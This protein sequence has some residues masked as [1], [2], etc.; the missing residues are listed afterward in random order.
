MS[1]LKREAN[2]IPLIRRLNDHYRLFLCEYPDLCAVC[3]LDPGLVRGNNFDLTPNLWR[4]E[5]LQPVL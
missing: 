4:S 2:E 1:L 3:A 5:I